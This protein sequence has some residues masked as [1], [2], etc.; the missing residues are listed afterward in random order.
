MTEAGNGT[1]ATPMG[2]GTAMNMAL[3]TGTGTA[4]GIALPTGVSALVQ[5]DEL[6][7]DGILSAM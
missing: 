4:V 2:I 6:D 5:G 1:N 3:L 7:E